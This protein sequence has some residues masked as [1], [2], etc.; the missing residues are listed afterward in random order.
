MPH[1]TWELFFADPRKFPPSLAYLKGLFRLI[2]MR[3][4]RSRVGY[5]FFF[6]GGLVSW[7]STLTT[8]LMSSSTEAECSSCGGWKREHMAKRLFDTTQ[9]FF[10][11]PAHQCFPR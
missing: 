8:R 5:F 11:H 9:S 4:E 6:L 3:L 1:G 2:V 10:F 7:C